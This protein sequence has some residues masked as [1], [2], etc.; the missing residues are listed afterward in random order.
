LIKCAFVLYAAALVAVA[1]IPTLP[2]LLAPAVLFGVAQ[3]M[4]LPNT[5]SLLSGHAP[6]ENRGAF[7][8]INGMTL[9]LGQTLGPLLMAATSGLLGLTS[10]FLAAAALA[11]VTFALVL[12][13]VR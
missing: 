5:F 10:A 7:M 8:S 11:A 2:L 9:R 1:L 12:V 3:S 6:A 13:L 4:N